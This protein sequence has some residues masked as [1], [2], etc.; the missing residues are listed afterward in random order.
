M[1]YNTFSI[2][3]DV[4]IDIVN[5][6]LFRYIKNLKQKIIFLILLSI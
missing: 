5:L 6:K 3:S 1:M 4:V 2:L